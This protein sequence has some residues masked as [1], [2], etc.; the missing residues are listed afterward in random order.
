MTF[1][2]RTLI[3]SV[4]ALLGA[5]A[6]APQ[7]KLISVHDPALDKG[8]GITLV[9]DVCTRRDPVGAP[10][11]HVL[12]EA[13]AG[14]EAVVQNARAFLAEHGV[15]VREALVPYSC[16]IVG[17]GG[18]S[19]KVADHIDAPVRE[20]APPF[21]VDTS[22]PRDLIQALR[23]VGTFVVQTEFAARKRAA[24]DGKPIAA[25]PHTAL[26]A[27][28]SRI[29]QRTS[30]GSVVYISVSARSMSAEA[31]AASTAGRFAVG[32]LTG[33]VTRTVSVVPGG[34]VDGRQMFAGAVDLETGRLLWSHHV[35][36]RGD[37]ADAATVGNR[38]TLENLLS[39]LVRRAE[40]AN[41]EARK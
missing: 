15:K 5:C 16:G 18:A 32:L 11:Y 14:A 13:R 7:P 6:T 2:T 37:P 17:G 39:G 12:A 29:A 20:A 9:V 41:A 30:G 1:R 28:A 23:Q 19:H 35:G 25:P 33:L 10:N 40:A 34:D 26:Q 22:M 27:P 8:G 24:A 21:A 4:A 3:T 36:A 31:S 38:P